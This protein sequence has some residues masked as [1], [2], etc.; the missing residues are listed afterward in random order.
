MK[1][2][3]SSDQLVMKLR[4]QR[5]VLIAEMLGVRNEENGIWFDK[6]SAQVSYLI[7]KFEGDEQA[8]LAALV[9]LKKGMYGRR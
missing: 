8:T 3:I 9:K 4:D 7:L 5:N 6:T 2:L 1:T